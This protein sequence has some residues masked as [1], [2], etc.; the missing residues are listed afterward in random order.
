MVWTRGRYAATRQT[1]ARGREG[2]IAIER[3]GESGRPD[4][5]SE[6]DG[7]PHHAALCRVTRCLIRASRDERFILQIAFCVTGV[8]LCTT[9]RYLGH[10]WLT[11]ASVL[12]QGTGNLTRR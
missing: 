8:N 5:D 10:F 11:G 12:I 4:V 1:R 2:E 6:F 9:K 3:C 7:T